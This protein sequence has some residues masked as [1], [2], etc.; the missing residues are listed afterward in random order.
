MQLGTRDGK[1]GA[2]FAAEGAG[3][4]QTVQLRLV[5]Q[6]PTGPHTKRPQKTHKT[7]KESQAVSTEKPRHEGDQQDAAGQARPRGH[8]F[9]CERR[10]RRQDS[11]RGPSG[12][13]AVVLSRRSP[14]GASNFGY[15][16]RL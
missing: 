9:K 15:V 4:Q 2:L 16:S 11:A 14:T 10:P 1:C 3:L 6:R 5:L 13:A 7:R 12:R 8:W